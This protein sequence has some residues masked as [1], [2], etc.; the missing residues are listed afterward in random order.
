MIIIRGGDSAAPSERRGTT[1]TGEVWA[2][3]VLPGTDGVLV[4]TIVF[5]PG[6]R[7]FWHRHERGQILQVLAG[8]G[9]VCSRGGQ[10]QCLRVGD[11]VWVPPGEQHWHG[12]SPDSFMSHTAISLG[13]TEWDEEV[14]AGDYAAAD[15]R[16]RGN[17]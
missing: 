12:A 17:A 15:G 5:T 10:P 8:F 7:T 4:N 16:G 9:L 3:P 2:Q 1:F 11:T 13:R 14:A 6:A